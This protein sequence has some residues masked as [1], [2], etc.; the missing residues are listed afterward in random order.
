L[1][2]A[3]PWHVVTARR[4]PIAIRAGSE[5]SAPPSAPG[6]RV[7]SER[8]VTTPHQLVDQV[9]DRGGD[10]L[11]GRWDVSGHDGRSHPAMLTRRCVGAV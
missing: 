1:G 6:R 8:P 11:L 7:W 2:S 4:G 9:R 5:V 10:G 3:E